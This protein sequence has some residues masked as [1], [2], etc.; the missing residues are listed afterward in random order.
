MAF[1]FWRSCVSALPFLG[2]SLPGAL[3]AQALSA[4][5]A[6]PTVVPQPPPSALKTTIQSKKQGNVA[7]RFRVGAGWHS[8]NI[9]VAPK[10][11]IS[12]LIIGPKEALSHVRLHGVAVPDALE[13][14][15]VLPKVLSFIPPKG[16]M[17]VQLALESKQ[18]LEIIQLQTPITTELPEDATPPLIGMPTP[19]D[20]KDGYVLEHPN[21]YQFA[22][23]DVIAMLRKGLRAMRHKFAR[24]SLGIGDLSQW[25]GRRPRLDLGKARHVSHE[26]GRD[27]DIALPST[28]GFSSLIEDRCKRLHS[29]GRKQAWC[30][31]GSVKSFDGARL[32]YLLATLIKT[33]K[34]DKIFLDHEYIGIVHRHAK[35]LARLQLIPSW[36]VEKLHPKNGVIHHL[37]WHTDHV[38]VRF[39]VKE[40][41]NPINAVNP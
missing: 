38:H 13:E 5:S 1:S 32:A 22:R 10:Q 37:P 18:A 21:R 19:R 16:V 4:P 7:Q 23:P 3:H 41:V 15:G 30:E 27:V 26:G 11:L 31:P 24:D 8:L 9:K 20:S 39:L 28:F 2:A 40:G 6:R 34:I 12:L 25:D 29:A 36:V 35:R 17:Q 14:D 33:Q